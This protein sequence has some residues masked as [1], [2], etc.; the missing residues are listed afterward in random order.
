MLIS[1]YDEWRRLKRRDLAEDNP[2]IKCPE[3]DG[4][5]EIFDHCECCGADKDEECGECDGAGRVRFNALS[6]TAK[7]KAFTRR[8]Y[9]NEVMADLKRWC[10]LTRQDYLGIAGRFVSEMRKQGVRSF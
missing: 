3:C 5:G 7:Q 2:L 1:S 9:V 4:E 6:D 10:S 8:M